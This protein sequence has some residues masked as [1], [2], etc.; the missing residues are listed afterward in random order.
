MVLSLRHI[1]FFSL[2]FFL[3][4]IALAQGPS[5]PKPTKVENP[6][7]AE[8][9]LSFYELEPN[10]PAELV[11][12]LHLPKGYRAYDDKF[13]IRVLEP[14]GFHYQGF[15]IEGLKN[16]RDEL[17]K[18]T[19][20]GVIENAKIVLPLEAPDH[21]P[22]GEHHLKV[23]ITYQACTKS[24]CLFPSVLIV[25]TPFHFTESNLNLDPVALPSFLQKPME[26]AKSQ[27]LWF[28]F[29]IVFL[30]GFLT[31]LT[32]CI[33]PIIPI[34]LTVLGKE[35]HDHSRRK[36]L[37]FSLIY[38]LGIAL[39]YASL[40]VM[41]AAT[42][43]MFGRYMSHPFVLSAVSL[44]FLAMSLS[45]FGFFEVQAP[46]FVRNLL[47][48]NLKLHGATKA[49]VYG[50]IAGVVAGPCVGPVL[51]G[52]LTYVAKTQNLWLGFWLLFVFALGMG[53]L[54]IALGFSS[55]LVKRLPK[56]G[57]WMVGVSH[58]FGYLM[59][60]ASAYYFSLLLPPRIWNLAMGAGTLI[61]G[62]LLKGRHR[63]LWLATFLFFSAATFNFQVS[64]KTAVDLFQPSAKKLVW[65]EF[66]PANLAAA[67]GRPV[68]VDFWAEWCGACHELEEKTFTSSEFQALAPDFVLLKFDATNSTDTLEQLQKDYDIIGL[69]TL[70]LFDETGAW[71]K[72]LKITE[73]IEGPELAAKMKALLQK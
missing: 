4:G 57:A 72:D 8:G 70:L 17:T 6:L 43:T 18:S 1:L 31:S 16:F 68:F 60:G 28:T 27:G 32:P 64:L 23:E 55:R 22:S 5:S 26:S 62:Y 66:T 46:G 52:I 40:G 11:L 45:L 41:A 35:V 49:F 34:T 36:T 9:Q 73:F 53:Q 37:A 67:K 13:K 42:G 25:S 2:G 21:L 56:S 10:K 15:K 48:G 54:F 58:F 71:R 19:K 38:V 14:E 39:S 63:V 30:A 44:V 65:K 59:L 29:V 33:F 20:L 24:Y 50:V 7:T 51:V 3:F 12:S 69:P 47:G 61:L